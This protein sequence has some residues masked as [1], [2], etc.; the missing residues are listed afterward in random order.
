[1]GVREREDCSAVLLF[2]LMIRRPPRSTL[3]PYTTLF[4]SAIAV[5]VAGSLAGITLAGQSSGAAASPVIAR[6]EE[7]TSELQ[8]RS[9][10]VCRLLLEKKKRG[11]KIDL[12][13]REDGYAGL[14]LAV[15]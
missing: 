13:E 1:M 4:R 9:D 11:R 7:H 3:F 5:C 12:R 2:F 14:A 10:L 6:S 8:S 15:C